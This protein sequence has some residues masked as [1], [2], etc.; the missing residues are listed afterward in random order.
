MLAVWGHDGIKI[1]D[2]PGDGSRDVHSLSPSGLPHLTQCKYH[3]DLTRTVSANDLGELPLGL[4]RLGYA[5][6]LFVTNARISPQG[7]RDYIDGYPGLSLNYMQGSELAPAVF[8]SSILRALWY[9]GETLDR[10]TYALVVPF[11]A[12]DL[13]RDRPV[14][15]L[16]DTEEPPSAEELCVPLRKGT[17]SMRVR[18]V[19]TA[20]SLFEPYSS[21]EV[22]TASEHWLPEV[23][24]AE[25][26]LTGA[27]LLRDLDAN[28]AASA[29]WLAERLLHRHRH[30]PC[31]YALRR[32]KVFLTPLGGESA[33]VRIK[34]PSEPA[35]RVILADVDYDEWDWLMPDPQ[36]GW[37]PPDRYSASEAE[38]VRWYNCKMD[39]CLA[40]SLLSSP[41]NVSRCHALMMR[42]SIQDAWC[43][44]QFALVPT[45]RLNRLSVIP[46]RMA[47][48]GHGEALCAWLVPEFA[49][50]LFPSGLEQDDQDHWYLDMDPAEETDDTR[51]IEQAVSLGGRAL[52]PCQARHMFAAVNA[53]PYPDVGA[54]T[55][56]PVDLLSNPQTVASPV[57]PCGRRIAFDICWSLGKDVDVGVLTEAIPRLPHSCGRGRPEFDATFSVQSGVDR[58]A[59]LLA[60]LVLKEPHLSSATADLLENAEPALA[61]A[62]E[63]LERRISDLGYLPRRA[64]AVFWAAEIG[65]MFRSAP[66]QH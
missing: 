19:F 62:L 58:T 12:R 59:F 61:S 45:A 57:D 40:L 44:S 18:P 60:D 55:Y 63:Q 8:E 27:A 16:A 52:D 51:C 35:T 37:V 25:A 24:S 38:W 1:T 11:I 3:H 54:V 43:R 33:G 32:G 29:S 6:G 34:L 5:E 10:V 56:R 31:H 2:G 20:M 23:R 26:V 41:S 66:S 42:A 30:G 49:T 14:N 39:V 7:K 53:D 9:D 50:G 64:T 22:K 46:S 21:P 47:D 4:H 13:V 36:R 65:L 48:W 17:V 28:L 15:L